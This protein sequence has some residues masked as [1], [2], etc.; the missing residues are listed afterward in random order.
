MFY[1]IFMSKSFKEINIP[2]R[3]IW[4]VLWMYLIMPV[5]AGQLKK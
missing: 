2:Y 3:Q 5:D 1:G 4:I